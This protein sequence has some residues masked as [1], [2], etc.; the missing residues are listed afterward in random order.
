MGS[1]TIIQSQLTMLPNQL[2]ML[3][4]QLI[5][6]LSQL[7]MLLNRLIMLLNR[8]IMPRSQLTI[9]PNQPMSRCQC[10]SQTT[11]TQLGMLSQHMHTT[12]GIRSVLSKCLA[13]ACPATT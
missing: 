5:M 9:L 7:I 2:I 13:S 10:T 3:Q 12:Q 11:S 4:N 8:P 6:L 1:T